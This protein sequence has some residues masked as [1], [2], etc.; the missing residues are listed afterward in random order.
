MKEM[1]KELTIHVYKIQ[2]SILMCDNQ[3]LDIMKNHL[4]IVLLVFCIKVQSQ[5]CTNVEMTESQANQLPW[6]GN[7]QFLDD[8]VTEKIG[9][10]NARGRVSGLDNRYFIPIRAVI[11][12]NNFGQAASAIS[13]ADV[14]ALI[15]E[16]NNLYQNANTLIRFFVREVVFVNNDFYRTQLNSLL[17]VGD[18]FISN[19]QNGVI[20]MHFVRDVGGSLSP[21]F[22]ISPA[23]PRFPYTEYS[24]YI[25][26]HSGSTYRGTARLVRTIAHELG[27]NFGLLHTHHPG[28]Y[29]SLLQND[30]NATIDNKCYQELVSRTHRNNLSCVST[31]NKLSCDVNGD[32]L[33]DTAADPNISPGTP[34]NVDSNCNYT[35][36]GGGDYE[37]DQVGNR[38]SPPTRNIMSYTSTECSVE[39]TWGQRA[40]MWHYIETD[41][42]S[43]FDPGFVGSDLVCSFPNSTYSVDLPSEIGVSWTQSSNL[44]RVSSTSTNHSYTVR[45]NTNIVDQ[46]GWI[47]VALDFPSGGSLNVRKPVKVGS[48]SFIGANYDLHAGMSIIPQGALI[49]NQWNLVTIICNS[50]DCSDFNSS[51]WEFRATNSAVNHNSPAYNHA[52]IMPLSSSSIRVDF[53]RINSCGASA[54]FPKYFEVQSSS[55]GGLGGG[56]IGSPSLGEDGIVPIRGGN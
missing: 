26:T 52:L 36:T 7:N 20:N 11:Y 45:A 14:F 1:L 5:D 4:F 13:E 30:D 27:H 56:G 49:K 33:C 54:W 9:S 43:E 48:P 39:F 32:F 3:I 18:L 25:S 19:R 31:Y 55:G 8:I 24:N 21:G 35:W 28:R 2:L 51:Q 42:L 17:D 38:W 16:T 10:S 22:A 53:R 12:R 15:E 44:S 34:V 46:D 6:F 23:F 40:V 29:V 37:F 50:G 47:Q 41:F